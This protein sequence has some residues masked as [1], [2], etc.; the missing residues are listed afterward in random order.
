MD[1]ADDEQIHA[2][3]TYCLRKPG[4]VKKLNGK[5]NLSNLAIGDLL[6]RRT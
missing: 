6:E 2:S 4:A 3:Y 5:F 1:F